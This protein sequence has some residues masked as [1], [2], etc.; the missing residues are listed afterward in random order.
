MSN[1]ADWGV[2]MMT[3]KKQLFGAALLIAFMLYA[4]PADAEQKN[5]VFFGFNEAVALA[6]ELAR[7]P[8]QA[9]SDI[10]EFLSEMDYEQWRGIRF[11]PDQSIWRNEA[12]PFQIQFLHTGSIYNRSVKINIIECGKVRP[13]SFS[14]DQ[15]DYGKYSFP[16]KIPKNM[17]YAGFRLHYP[18]IGPDA[19]NYSD[20]KDEVLVFLGASYFQAVGRGQRFGVSA[21]GLS[22]DP[23]PGAIEEYPFF[24]EFWLVKPSGNQKSMTLFALMDSPSISAAYKFDVWPGENTRVGVKSIVFQRHR[25]RKLGFAPLTTM[26]FYG[27]NV[28]QRPI[29]DFRPEIHDSDVMLIAAGDQKWISRPLRNPE[30]L[31]V[32]RYPVF[33]KGI[34]ILI[35]T[36]TCNPIFIIV[37][38]SG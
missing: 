8:Y 20:H 34:R 23:G 2:W 35:I 10:P 27:E 16:E 17:G 36:R 32:S 9:P 37:R 18:I 15:F 26:F 31:S 11:D 38:V 14:P 22:I 13:V 21:R 19:P 33:S 24:K 1:F 12:L 6:A 25:V 5:T 30:T 7:K 29:D 4:G 3:Q 28:N